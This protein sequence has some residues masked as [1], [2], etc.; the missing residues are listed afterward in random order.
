MY[1]KL[2]APHGI[3]A[4]HCGLQPPEGFGWFREEIHTLDDLRGRRMRLFGIGA[5]VMKKLGV[6]AVSLP[7][8]EVLPALTSGAID[9]V[10]FSTPVIDEKFGLYKGAG[11][12]YFPGWLQQTGA[13]ELL[14]SSDRWQALSLVQQAQIEAVCRS[15]MMHSAGAG[16][17][18]QSAALQV[19]RELGVR[20]H[21]W[22]PD[23]LKAMERAW[24]EVVS[25][26]SASDVD[27]AEIADAY[28]DFREWYSEWHDFGYLR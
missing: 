5:E 4:M 11:H 21:R 22:P 9:A 16:G 26:K 24:S 28:F 19:L 18:A 6:S 13:L 27:F 3:H 23:I 14:V 1:R 15:S 17:A 10:E 12:Y 7:G 25:E 20:F 8:S 2:Y